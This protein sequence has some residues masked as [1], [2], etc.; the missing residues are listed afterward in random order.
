MKIKSEVIDDCLNWLEWLGS[1][2]DKDNNEASATHLDW[3]QVVELSKMG[4]ELGCQ[5]DDSF[6][7]D[8]KG[9]SAISEPV[10]VRRFRAIHRNA[11]QTPIAF[12]HGPKGLNENGVRSAKKAG[13]MCAVTDLTGKADNEKNLFFLPRIL[14]GQQ[15]APNS[16]R[17]DKLLSFVR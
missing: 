17:L 5:D 15:N 1:P 3:N 10:W 8:S 9:E 2:T 13:F 7:D 11:G 14:I 12:C 6:R 16:H 4:W